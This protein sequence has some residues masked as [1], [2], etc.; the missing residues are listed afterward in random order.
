MNIQFAVL[1]HGAPFDDWHLRCVNS[2]LALPS[3]RA[4]LLIRTSVG[5]ESAA[6]W[7]PPPGILA[8]LPV[9]PA[10]EV[11][12]PPYADQG[13]DFI[14]SFARDPC[15]ANLI[16][17]ARYG[18]W[19]FRFGDSGQDGA[20]TA[21]FWEVHDGQS[22]TVARLVRLQAS[23]GAF[24]VLREGHLPTRLLSVG[25]N[26][27]EVLNRIA[28]WAALACTDLL[29]GVTGRSTAPP[30]AAA[31]PAR[32][33]PSAGDRLGCKVRVAARIVRTLAR[34][35][36]RHDHWNVGYIDRPMAWFLDPQRGAAPV[37]WLPAPTRDEFFADP[38]GTWRSGRLTILFERFDYRTNLGTIWAIEHSGGAPGAPGAPAPAAV[39]VRVGPQPEVHLSYPYLI[40]AG[41]RLLCIP[42]SHQ[43]AEIGLYEVERF[44]DRWVKIAD[45]VRGLPIVDAT[46]FRHGER[47]WLAGS[48]A[49]AK[50]TTCELH[51]WHADEIAGPWRAH[52][53]NP[54]KVDVRSARPAGTPFVK[55]GALYRPAQ[56]CSRTY[57]GRV[58]INR[59]DTLT[60]TEFRETP[61]AVV[62]PDPSGPYPSGLHT[63][64]AAGAGTLIDSKRTVFSPA[65]FR[66]V[67]RH[68]LRSA[69]ER[70]GG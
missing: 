37:A 48:E 49:T 16:D 26:R 19:A 25:A 62:E 3:V 65:E 66:R 58:V 56:D 4:S 34:S 9:V 64:S 18:V 59:V 27:R 52:A 11:S 38:F 50:G 45:L 40:D 21:G 10:S 69:L 47:W 54:V 7:R 68:Y 30:F 2:L 14:L 29:N 35:L 51:L 32:K 36:F 20:D 61:V 17:A 22:V 44:P 1:W 41:E 13:L 53:A 70:F 6:D 15:P 28:P 55:D 43:A 12:P 67:F 23:T 60:P 24:A 33:P 46:L 57:G 8:G 42:E 31:S 63:L 5:A 39:P